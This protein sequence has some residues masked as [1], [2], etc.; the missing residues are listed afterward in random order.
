M[1]SEETTTA[2]Y[3]SSSGS[4]NDGDGAFTDV[5]WVNGVDRVEDGRGLAIADLDRNGQLDLVV[6]NYR[7]PAQL[8]LNRGGAHH[9]LQLRLVGTRSNRD[10][11]GARVRV[12]T[13]AGW[14]TRAVAAGSAFLS[15]Q[16]LVQ[17][18]GLGPA[19]RAEAVEI[20][21]PSGLR[22]T[23][24]PLD[25]DRRWTVVEG[26]DAPVAAATVRAAAR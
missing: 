26:V 17:H 8:L 9:W 15:T 5:A 20:T 7:Q 12:L 19:T 24:G 2:P 6:R 13:A 18:V 4:R 16:S 1:G 3:S 25:G 22:Q 21:W 11:V 23:L 10:A 14:Q